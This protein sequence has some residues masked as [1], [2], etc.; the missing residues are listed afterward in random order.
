MIHTYKEV[1]KPCSEGRCSLFLDHGITDEFCCLPFVFE[2]FPVFYGTH[3]VT[4]SIKK[5]N[6]EI[7]GVVTLGYDNWAIGKY[8]GRS[9]ETEPERAQMSACSDVNMEQ[10][11]RAHLRTW[12]FAR[13]RA[14]GK[15]TPL[16]RP[17][18][19]QSNQQSVCMCRCLRLILC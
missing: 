5:E 16:P 10:D 8:Q 7:R 13:A 2:C 3:I 17:H 19:L 12:A 15:G 11:R 4:F 1:R 6:E 18:P 14:L 9:W